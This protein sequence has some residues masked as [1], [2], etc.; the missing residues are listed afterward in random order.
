[1][2]EEEENR[3]EKLRE[4]RQLEREAQPLVLGGD[5]ATKTLTMKEMKE[6]RLRRLLGATPSSTAIPSPS[7][8]HSASPSSTTASSTVSPTLSVPPQIP[9][10]SPSPSPAPSPSPPLGPTGPPTLSRTQSAPAISNSSATP[11]K[12]FIYLTETSLSY[13]NSP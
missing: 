6:L 8:S 11:T 2:K 10:S 3:L 9:F 13:F 7:P 4:Q 5:S 12:N 1:M